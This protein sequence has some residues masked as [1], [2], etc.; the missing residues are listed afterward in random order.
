MQADLVLINGNILTMDSKKP[1]A[2]A[3]AVKR[4]RILKV[5][6]NSEITKL[7]GKGTKTLNLK[8]KTV[9]PGLI[10]THI[11]VADFGRTLTWLDLK[12]AYSIEALQTLTRKRVKKT[13]RG[14]WIV[15]LGGNLSSLAEKRYPNYSDLDAVSLNSPVVIY[16]QTGRLAIVNSKAL[17]LAGIT[18]Q[19]CDPS[20]GQIDRDAKTG[21]PTGILRESATDLV[22]KA[23][24]EPDEEE[25]VEAAALACE[26]IVEA[27]V[28]TVHWIVSS[29]K[30]LA[31]IQILR[32]QNRLPLRVY[33]IVP[34][35]LI[36][37]IA[38][39]APLVD[40]ENDR[41]KVGGV[42][43][44]ADGFLAMQTAALYEPYSDDS[45]KKGSLF[46]DQRQMSTLITKVLKANLQV[47]I[48]ANGD[49]AIDVALKA[50]KAATQASR[51]DYRCRLE[52]AALLNEELIQR[53][54]KQK[55]TVSIQP[56][57]VES[58]FSIWSAYE[59]LG[60]DRA[61]WLYPIATLVKGGVRVV[62]GS[63]CPMEPLSP[64]SGIRAAISREFFPEERITLDDALRLYT[65]NA[66]YASFEESNI[67]SIEAGKLAD[68]AVLS[69]DPRA[70]PPDEIEA[71]RIEMTIV[72]GKIVH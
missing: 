49:R 22:W 69:R 3:V 24:P 13:A 20:N 14:K 51:R 47:I 31:A 41:V 23:M 2:E 10:D 4:N 39:I 63:D 38:T 61:R 64:F 59:H 53:I 65:V 60:R 58:E 52:Q 16:G 45:A 42:L 43:I 11:H 40:F 15:G 62:A 9:I 8:G 34:S 29:S 54:R 12:G 70:V 17:E 28:T 50:I 32:K 30:E 1:N 35:N 27:G 46:C 71:I 6:K 7:I 26:P 56:R 57:V 67:G 48:H 68:F 37:A 5:G 66:A 72:G 25:I 18:K 21:E 44:F 55:V 33:I 36:E 19:T